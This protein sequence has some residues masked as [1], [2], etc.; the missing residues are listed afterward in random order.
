[1]NLKSL[2]MNGRGMDITDDPLRDVHQAG[3]RATG[4][5]KRSE[6]ETANDEL[7]V[8]GRVEIWIIVRRIDR[9]GSPT[10]VGMLESGNVLGGNETPKVG[11]HLV[12]MNEINLPMLWI[13]GADLV[14][15]LK[16]LQEEIPR[17]QLREGG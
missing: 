15:L 7:E 17:C 1:M 2:A 12:S 13:E 9:N 4:V 10:I 8:A 11:G 6:N 14:R 3:L 16:G 5:I